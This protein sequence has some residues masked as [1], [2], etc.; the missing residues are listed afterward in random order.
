MSNR[1]F[2]WLPTLIIVWNSI[3]IAVHVAVDM[4]EPLR[5]S[6]NIIGIAAA[7]IVWMGLANKYAPHILS[8]AAVLTIIL[9]TICDTSTGCNNHSST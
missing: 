5:V 8:G 3:D 9:N 6:G 7:I 1:N 4:V 2:Q